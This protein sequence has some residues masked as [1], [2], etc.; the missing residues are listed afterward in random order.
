MHVGFDK[1]V[2]IDET[3]KVDSMIKSII[4]PKSD[5]G[6]GSSSVR[7]CDEN[8]Q[9]FDVSELSFFGS[10]LKQRLSAVKDIGEMRDI[11]G[12]KLVDAYLGAQIGEGLDYYSMGLEL[13]KWKRFSELYIIYGL[14]KDHGFAIPRVW[15]LSSQS[16][17]MFS[18]TSSTMSRAPST[19]VE[20]LN[21]VRKIDTNF[22]HP[23]LLASDIASP[24]EGGTSVGTS[25]PIDGAPNATNIGKL[26]NQFNN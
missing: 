9:K 8:V 10:E 6:V 11:Y 13:E 22:A 5:I 3:K 14:S 16:S 2:Q 1:N 23:F 4:S 12:D 26:I 18:A 21:H 19:D 17:E 20:I 24:A 15:E 25:S 7:T